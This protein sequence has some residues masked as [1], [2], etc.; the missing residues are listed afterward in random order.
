MIPKEKS[1]NNWRRIQL[2]SYK[3]KKKVNPNQDLK[4]PEVRIAQ[5]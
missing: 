4:Q 5:R 1:R 2:K 3:I